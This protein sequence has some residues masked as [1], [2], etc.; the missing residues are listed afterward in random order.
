M[1]QI[2]NTKDQIMEKASELLTR[3]GYKGFSYRDISTHLGVKNAAIHYH[4]P[5]KADLA[6]ALV[7]D[8]HQL[9]RR[10][11]AEFMAYGGSAQA[12]LEGLFSFTRSQFC[13]GH[14]ICPMGAFS[15]D[16]EELPEAVQKAT[17]KFLEDSTIWLTRVLEIGRSQKEFE[18]EGDP[19]TRALAILATLQGGR[20]IARVGGQEMLER[21]VT[22][23]RQDLNLST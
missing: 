8:Y 10:R 20:Q 17:A 22:E 21:I 9:L 5:T 23:I 11:T 18:F 19:R 6:L 1:N 15:V 4:F 3:H 2:G 13:K 16:Y 12:Q 7:E 14:C